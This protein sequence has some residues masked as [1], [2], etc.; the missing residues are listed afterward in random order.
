[1]S[2][3]AAE[4][5]AD[6]LDEKTRLVKAI[7]AEAQAVIQG[8]GDQAGYE[9]LMRKKAELLSKI[10]D[11]AAPLV[12]A[13]GRGLSDAAAERLGGFSHNAAMSLKVGSVFFMSALLYPDDHKPGEPNNLE[14]FAA[15]VRGWA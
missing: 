6:F 12:A 3:G 7:E 4:N 10:A 9:A 15:E 11:D 13:L 1:M 2:T 5:L 14:L 8:R